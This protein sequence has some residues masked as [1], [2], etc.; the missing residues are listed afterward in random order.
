MI[1]LSKEQFLKRCNDRGYIWAKIYEGNYK[2]I[3]ESL[4]SFER[5]D[6][7]EGA[8]FTE[9]MEV[10]A[11]EYPYKFSILCRSTKN[12]NPSNLDLLNVDFAPVQ[13]LETIANPTNLNSATINRTPEQIEA[14]I[15]ARL[16]LEIKL[17]QE[18]EER[19]RVENKLADLETTG[20]KLANVGYQIL[21]QFMTPSQP[22]PGASLQGT[23]PN[24]LETALGKLVD[25]LGAET[26]IK[27]SKKI[28]PGDPI[29]SMVKN[30]ANG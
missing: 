7:E 16:E 21:M 12:N 10:F 17:K 14:E 26:I 22:E 24:E 25:T 19:E 15:R 30:Y 3:D 8:E 20:G 1:T 4:K 13:T 23:N 6:L 9:K 2:K 27:L 29:I 28:G 18:T 11:N 5:V